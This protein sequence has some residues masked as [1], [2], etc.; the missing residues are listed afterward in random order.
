MGQ[1]SPETAEN[2]T[3]DA[4]GITRA[5]SPGALV[6]FSG[7]RVT[8]AAVPA[9][10]GVVD[11]GRDRLAEAG[12]VDPRVSRRHATAQWDAGAWVVRDVGSRNGT[13]VEGEPCGG[14]TRAGPFAVVRVGDTVAWLVPDL[15]P[16][17]DRPVKV[18]GPVVVGAA[19]GAALD[20]VRASA[21]GP[22]LHVRGPSGAGKEL[23][24]RV[25][26]EGGPRRAGPFV[27][28]NC[29]A[30]PE[31]VAERVLFGARKG[32]YSG[33]HADAPGHFQEADGGTLFLDEVGEL[34]LAVQAKLLRALE[35][36]EVTPLGASRPQRVDV[37]FCSAT[38]R[39][40]RERVSERRFREDL[41]YRVARPEVVLPA[42]RER[43]DEVPSL[44]ALALE[45]FGLTAHPSLIE[46]CLARPWP[47]NVRELLVEVAAAARAAHGAP[48]KRV[49]AADL[50]PTAGMSFTAPTVA[51]PS[52]DSDASDDATAQPPR[53][54]M[55]PKEEIV[56]S[57]RRHGG[58]VATAARELG[59]HR[60][61]LRRWI[62]AEGV[63][64]R[65]LALAS[66]GSASEL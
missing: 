58:R 13:A 7:G 4:R 6:L 18:E 33:A 32:A 15:G 30:I 17:I 12:V 21:D 25:F 47:G 53:R 44:V 50:S 61:Q 52:D 42:L 27:A 51:E 63:D 28:I 3:F 38:H 48:D 55:P 23:A 31:G 41:Y 39:D 54:G 65:A 10:D 22:V 19:L 14:A 11:L 9:R 24:A 35:S 29:A 60:N 46:A 56:A 66:R 20:R 34:D 49:R 62:A 2:L 16:F 45:P 57:L 59:L 1:A 64:P 40:L 37:R 8:H 26:H 36:R 43:R 5:P